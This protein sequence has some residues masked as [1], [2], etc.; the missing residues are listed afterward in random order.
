MESDILLSGSLAW[1]IIW[2][3]LGLK[4][5]KEHLVWLDKMEKISTEGDL[6]KFWSTFDGF[7]MH[8][9]AHAHA[10]CFSSIAFALGLTMKAGLIDY[11]SIFLTV[12][13]VWLLVG[14]VLASVGDYFRSLPIVIPG[15]ILF[16]TGLITSFIGLLI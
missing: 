9:A 6:G 4:I 14:I 10:I 12:L 8:V 2:S 7:K 15:N 16:L 3:I 13:S 11:S 5:G 1:I